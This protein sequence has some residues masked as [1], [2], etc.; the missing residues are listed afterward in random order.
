MSLNIMEDIYCRIPLN[1]IPWN[2]E[3]PP[4]LLVKLIDSKSIP[5][6]SVLDIGC[7]AGN[8]SIFLAKRGFD[9]VG[10]DVS[11]EAIRIARSQAKKHRVSCQFYTIDVIE[12]FDFFEGSFDFIFDW[13]LLHHIFP[14]YR[15][16]YV[17]NVDRL[18][19]AEG[20]YL[21]VCFHEDD[22]RF[23]GSG[24]IRKTSLG[25]VLYFSSEKELYDLFS[26]IFSIL[27]F[28]KLKMG[29]KMEHVVNFVFMSKI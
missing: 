13:Q 1:E 6:G 16:N 4:D 20:R 19:K 17:I 12:D 3:D 25:T 2:N 29:V 23:G 14:K 7:G 24:K 27:E 9:V 28:K 5:L 8:Y 15:K 10:I 26:P 11:K 18:L 21:S 22:L